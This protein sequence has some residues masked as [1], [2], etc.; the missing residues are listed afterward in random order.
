MAMM[1]D[2]DSDDSDGDDGDDGD[3]DD[4]VNHLIAAFIDWLVVL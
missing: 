2:G 4:D 3:G 1:V